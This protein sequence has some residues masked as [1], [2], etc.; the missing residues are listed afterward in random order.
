MPTPARGGPAV[1]TLVLLAGLAAC[2][3]DG[4]EEGADAPADEAVEAPAVP[5]EVVVGEVVGEP[6]RAQRTAAAQ[7]VAAVVDGWLDAAYVEASLPLAAQDVDAGTFPGF[8]PGAARRAADDAPA[9]TAAGLPEGT[10]AVE[11]LQRRVAVDLLGP[12]RG[13]PEAA[14]A[15]VLLRLRPSVDGEALR[16]VARSGRLLLTRGPQGWRVFGYDLRK[17]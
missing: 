14:T 6:P 4:A 5:T 7:E 12:R 2:T 11:V 9:T 3:S 1:V 10:T 8:T 13:R 17:G 16:P 15:R